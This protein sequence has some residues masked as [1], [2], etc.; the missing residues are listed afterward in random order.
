[1][2]IAFEMSNWI[3]NYEW[4]H[5]ATLRKPWK[6]TDYGFYSIMN[7]LKRRKE[8]Y[9]LFGAMEY[10]YQTNYNHIHLLLN[11]SIVD[12]TMLRE[13]LGRGTDNIVGY[14]EEVKDNQAVSRYCTKH[15]YKVQTWDI[16]I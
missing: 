3:N 6:I 11:T 8:I 12:R 9:S 2:N 10:D 5:I 16:K 15:L 14:M 4:S 1:M 7:K 13:L